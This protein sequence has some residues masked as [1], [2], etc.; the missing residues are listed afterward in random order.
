VIEEQGKLMFKLQPN[1]KAI[2]LA[3]KLFL[4]SPKISYSSQVKLKSA[5]ELEYL[6]AFDAKVAIIQVAEDKREFSSIAIPL[7]L[8]EQEAHQIATTLNRLQILRSKAIDLEIAAT[9]CLL[10]GQL[11]ELA[12]SIYKIEK[13]SIG[14]G[15]QVR[16]RATQHNAQLFKFQR[17]LLESWSA[18]YAID[19]QLDIN[20]VYIYLRE[21]F[22]GVYLAVTN[23]LGPLAECN[24]YLLKGDEPHYLQSL[25]GE[26]SIGFL[27]N[28]LAASR[29]L[30]CDY[31]Q[32][33][34]VSMLT[35]NFTLDW[36]DSYG[37]VIVGSEPI[38]FAECKQLASSLYEISGLV[39]GYFGHHVGEL[40]AGTKVI[41][42]DANLSKIE[43]PMALEIALKV[44]PPKQ[45]VD[46]AKPIVHKFSASSLK[47][48][49]PLALSYEMGKISWLPQ[50]YEATSFIDYLSDESFKDLRYLVQGYDQNHEV[51]SQALVEGNNA[52]PFAD[53]IYAV[54][55][56]TIS[57]S[58]NVSSQSF[59]NI[60]TCP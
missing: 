51:I 12:N 52:G 22:C 50:S 16:L 18:D 3:E 56:A 54:S 11:F 4:Q 21:K 10:P 39:R 58:G 2:N 24:I 43:L 49:P 40:A 7:L 37:L 42:A 45:L 47:P 28:D 5:I 34:V 60:K 6:N 48:L 55:V 23:L 35:A 9:A 13:I 8:E 14:S 53:D 33:L 46:D 57:E 20:I 30:V 41:I 27:V 17:A 36:L 19:Y 29:G 25:E 15:Y 26:A 59:V 31:S 38:L 32:A 1:A 44:V